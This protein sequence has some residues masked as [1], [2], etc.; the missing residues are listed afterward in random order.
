[1]TV[2]EAGHDADDLRDFFAILYDGDDWAFDSDTELEEDKDGVK[3]KDGTG[4]EQQNGAG[5][6]DASGQAVVEDGGTLADGA[7]VSAVATTRQRYTR[8]RISNP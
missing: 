8:V 2:P 1:M 4:E 7:P 5:G 6:A 3:Q